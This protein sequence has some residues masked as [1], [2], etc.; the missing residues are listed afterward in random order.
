MIYVKESELELVKLIESKYDK[1]MIYQLKDK[2]INNKYLIEVEVLG[3]VEDCI[4]HC[5]ELDTLEEAE[6]QAYK[7]LDMREELRKEG[8]I[9]QEE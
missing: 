1:E 5:I 9:Y 8:L 7:F 4:F 6:K 2:S 3:D